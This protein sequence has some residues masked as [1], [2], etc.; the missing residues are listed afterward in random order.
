MF[1]IMIKKVIKP[2]PAVYKYLGP[3]ILSISK[4][5]KNDKKQKINRQ[6]RKAI[7]NFDLFLL[8]NGNGFCSQIKMDAV[9]GIG[10]LFNGFTIGAIYYRLI[11]MLK[12]ALTEP[13]YVIP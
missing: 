3:I 6:N 5:W 10:R 2:N 8:E 9:F 1:N 4:G 7:E 12:S 13:V 11:R